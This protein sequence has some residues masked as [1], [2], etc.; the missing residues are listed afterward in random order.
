MLG[1][2]RARQG[3]TYMPKLLR[4]LWICTH[5]ILLSSDRVVGWQ[6][7]GAHLQMSLNVIDVFNIWNGS[8]SDAGQKY[9]PLCLY[10]MYNVHENGYI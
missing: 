7:A 9:F 8:I 10:D 1:P 3:R 5:V 6:I 4:S 2:S